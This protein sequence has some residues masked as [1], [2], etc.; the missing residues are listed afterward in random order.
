MYVDDVSYVDYY[1]PY[2]ETH[3]KVNNAY[4]LAC[5]HEVSR[6]LIENITNAIEK[7]G[8]CKIGGEND[9]VI[10]SYNEVVNSYLNRLDNLYAFSASYSDVE[11]IYCDLLVELDELKEYDD[12]FLAKK[13]ERPALWQYPVYDD[14]GNESF[15]ESRYYADLDKYK[16]EVTNYKK[17]CQALAYNIQNFL[18]YL[19]SVNDF[20]PKDGKIQVSVDRPSVLI[21]AQLLDKFTNESNINFFDEN[22]L[23][24]DPLGGDELEQFL[25]TNDIP[26]GEYAI[27]YKKT[28]MVNGIPITTYSVFDKGCSPEE[29]ASFERYINKSLAY[30][31]KIDPAILSKVFA[32][33]D[34]S[35]VIF[36]QT[37]RFDPFEYDDSVVGYYWRHTHNITMLYPGYRFDDFSTA[38]I[39][40]ETGHAYDHRLY[41][42]G[43]DNQSGYYSENTD[44]KEIISKEV[45]YFDCSN[46]CIIPGFESKEKAQEYYDS[47][48]LNAT[49]YEI[50]ESDGEWS[51]KVSYQNPVASHGVTVVNGFTSGYVTH[52]YV[53]MPYEYFADS[54]MAYW[55]GDK[56][57]DEEGGM[58]RLEFLCPETYAELQKLIENDK[59]NYYGGK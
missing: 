57:S 6:N 55:L 50:V 1:S 43:N 44:W 26:N 18:D 46:T 54:F 10:A 56:E 51:I 34:A 19:T 31:S 25:K 17:C 7:I 9:N 52:D 4:V 41:M 12:K 13:I 20:D 38:A 36:L 21:G 32:G 28:A 45:N 39:V 22:I 14:E 37:S 40:H 16:T 5:S 53:K 33:K 35:S 8:R 24:L 3:E 59:N 29:N 58:S 48:C 23:G 47:Y 11:T 27:V 15:D 42:E 49:D 2:I 30:E